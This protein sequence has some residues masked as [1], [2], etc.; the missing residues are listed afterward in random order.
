MTEMLF[1]TTHEGTERL[2]EYFQLSGQQR[3]L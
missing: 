1:E 3:K 2:G